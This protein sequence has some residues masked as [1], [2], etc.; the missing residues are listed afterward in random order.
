MPLLLFQGTDST[1]KQMTK[2]NGYKDFLKL[3]LQQ[4]TQMFLQLLYF[5][6]FKTFLVAG[7]LSPLYPFTP[8]PATVTMFPKN[9]TNAMTFTFRNV[10]F[11]P[12]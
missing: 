9:F 12:R 11:I 3:I 1:V 10:N 7:I 4:V 6:S 5:H 2:M 8:V